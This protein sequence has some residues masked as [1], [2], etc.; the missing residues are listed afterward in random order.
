MKLT[1]NLDLGLSGADVT[2]LQ[3]FLKS[4]NHLTVN[5]TGYFGTLTQSAVASFQ[6]EEGIVLNGTPET[7][8]LGRV[9][10]TTRSIIEKIS[11]VG[12]SATNTTNDFFGYNLDD[13]FNNP[14]S[15]DYDIDFNTDIAY[16]TSIDFDEYEI[17]DFDEIDFEDFDFDFDEIEFDGNVSGYDTSL[18]DDVAVLLFAKAVNGEYL[19]GGATNPVAVPSADVELAWDS[20]KTRDCVLSGDLKEKR[21]PVPM[22]GTAKLT[23][24]TPTGG[25][26]SNGDSLFQ[27][28]VS[29]N[30]STTNPYAL[31]VGDTIKLW[32]YNNQ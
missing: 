29:C 32:I 28:R 10:P 27:F 5:P 14:P 19:R 2:S 21:I 6:K 23:V 12:S 8:G 31:P 13:L 4:K 3:E 17:D 26:A 25:K 18:K 7:T 15:L 20:N 16:D 30:A 24:T 9:G 1:R 11:C 22:R